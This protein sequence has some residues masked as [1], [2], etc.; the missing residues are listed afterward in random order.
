MPVAVDV[1]G[2]GDP[3]VLVHGLATTRDIWRL[4]VP[5]LAGSR[6]VAVLDVPGFGASTPAGPGFDL[7][8]VADRLREGVAGAGI[9]EPYDLVGHSMGGALALVLAYRHP[10]EVRRLVRASRGAQRIRPALAAVASA[11]LR[12]LVR[13]VRA[14]VSVLI[15]ASDRVVRP[16]T[17]D[18]VR[19]LRP[20]AA[21]ETIA[22]AAHISMIERPAEFVAALE[23]VLG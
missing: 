11:D 8:A 21:C 17:L 20:D 22:G 18:T 9:D 12:G 4:V 19:R 6:R 5:P 10:A 3:L 13:E 14:P 1:T 23:R 7:E 2:Q 15:G 16:G